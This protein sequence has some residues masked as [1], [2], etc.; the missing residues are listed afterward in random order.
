MTKIKRSTGNVRLVEYSP[1]NDVGGFHFFENVHVVLG[2]ELL[3]FLVYHLLS[4][5]RQMHL[6]LCPFTLLRDHERTTFSVP[7]L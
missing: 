1:F 6:F 2:E 7:S 3:V 5:V 4:E